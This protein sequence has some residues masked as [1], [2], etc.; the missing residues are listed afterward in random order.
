M[1]TLID[2]LL[3]MDREKMQIVLWIQFKGC[4]RNPF[5]KDENLFLLFSLRNNVRL[6]E[7]KGLIQ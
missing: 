7:R 2:I 3:M 5:F 4:E 6:A 1:F